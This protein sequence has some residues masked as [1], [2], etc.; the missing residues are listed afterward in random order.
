MSKCK[1]CGRPL[2]DSQERTVGTIEYKSCPSCSQANGE[3]HIF[4]KRDLFGYTDRRV[5]RNTPDGVQSYCVPCRGGD[6]P[7]QNGIKC[8]ELDSL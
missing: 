1:H 3:E 5:T 8:S 7:P 4:Y 6:T 2:K